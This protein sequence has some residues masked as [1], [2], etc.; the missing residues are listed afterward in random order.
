MVLKLGYCLF[1]L[2]VSSGLSQK[3]VFLPLSI[4]FSLN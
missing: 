3:I 2:Y 4:I 1:L